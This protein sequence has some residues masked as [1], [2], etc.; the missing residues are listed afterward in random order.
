MDY[1]AREPTGQVS[2]GT[3]ALL[4]DHQVNVTAV[5]DETY[6]RIVQK[7]VNQAGLDE[8]GQVDLYVDPRSQV[9]TI[10]AL[11]VM[12]Q[13]KI[14]D[15]AATA[16]FT[17]LPVE[18]ELE[19]RTYRGFYRINIVLADVRVGDV[20][21]VAYTVRTEEKSFPGRFATRAQ[22]EWGA[23]LHE[24]RV[25]FR[26]PA[27]RPMKVR[28]SKPGFTVSPVT[29][30]DVSEFS[31]VSRDPKPILEEPGRPFWHQPWA[32]M[33]VSDFPDWGEVAGRYV[34]LFKLGKRSRPRLDAL[35][36]E[37]GKGHLD[38]EQRVSQ[39]L[40][41]VQDNIRYTSISIERGAFQPSDPEVVLERRFGDC[42]DK[43]LLLS[44]I[45]RRY[46]IDAT[47]ALVN[48]FRGR[49]LPQGLPSAWVFDHAI[50]RVR[51]AGGEYWVD[52]TLYRQQTPLRELAPPDF[53][54]ALVVAPD[55]TGLAV[56]PRPSPSMSRVDARVEW[57]LRNGQ[58][59]PATMKLE[60]VF[61]GNRAD[62][63]RAT[64]AA[65]SLEAWQASLTPFL[66]RLYPGLRARGLPAVE[67]DPSGNRL[68]VTAHF[69]ID[70][71]F[72]LVGKRWEFVI[73]DE[74]VYSFLEPLRSIA[75]T[76]PLALPYPAQIRQRT[77]VLLPALWRV[78]S[79]D[80]KVENPAFRYTA[81]QRYNDFKVALVR[82]FI[83]LK[84]AVDVAELPRFQQDLKRVDAD[85]PF[86][87]HTT[88]APVDVATLANPKALNK[89]I[90]QL[91]DEARNDS[92][93]NRIVDSLAS[94][95]TAP[96]FG[97]L[98][99]EVRHKAYAADGDLAVG[100][101]NWERGYRSSRAATEFAE[102]TARDWMFLAQGARVAGDLSEAK[103]AIAEIARRW[104]DHLE[105]MPA[106]IVVDIL[107]VLGEEDWFDLANIL[108]KSPLTG[109]NGFAA[110]WRRLA[111]AW[112]EKG[113][114]QRARQVVA[115]I[116][117]PEEMI[118]ARADRRFAAVFAGATTV[119]DIAEVAATGLKR[120]KARTRAHPRSLWVL[121]EWLGELLV[122]K[123]YDEV[124]EQSEEA[125]DALADVKPG[126]PTFH[127]LDAVPWIQDRRARALWALNRRD[128]A[129]GLWTQ[130]GPSVNLGLVYC[131][132]NRAEDALRTIEA[133]DV[134]T[135]LDKI[136][137]SEVRLC[138]TL[139]RKDTGA[140]EAALAAMR[141][142]RAQSPRLY[143]RA[144]IWSSRLD[145]AAAYLRERLADPATRGD[146]LVDVQD[147]APVPVFSR[148][149]DFTAR[150]QQV[151]KREDV[152]KAIKAVGTVES[153]PFGPPLE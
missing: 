63:K 33:E 152:K 53:E 65:Q 122:A 31:Y 10:H 108:S 83:N 123:E 116:D 113:D 114:L 40:Q 92:D 100:L 52:P 24:Q 144:L 49:T 23:P 51:T 13:G 106:N 18:T 36:A 85:S 14:T 124:L 30:R 69:D 146:A 81:S 86:I 97:S 37:L 121:H 77:T 56:I 20:V 19:R 120:L 22:L 6:F 75:R 55:T 79:E 150:W 50:V 73:H 71:V 34:N 141:D 2:N 130:A 78:D 76:T 44:T 67:D 110:T 11:Q 45:L 16:R 26:Y 145:E 58:H 80:F 147:Y 93:F 17:E 29:S 25:R 101:G 91:D 138:A 104:P 28:F 5:G 109:R 9:L 111:L 57:D 59:Q 7:A 148:P 126:T 90:L 48:T 96:A 140:A 98:S 62:L 128:E 84:D 35:A 137:V 94:V 72:H 133:V 1:N 139:A 68:S 12:R 47:P 102:T 39:V 89:L 60:F 70:K 88:I 46:G 143:Q 118:R 103:R 4:T 66:E 135:E 42:K 127:D 87:L 142:G 38:A 134:E 131:H 95:L 112:V 82:E 151:L 54:Q 153:Y 107:A 15:A 64:F 115:L 119:P 8:A 41:H 117:E 43:A 149:P 125:L 21:D 32:I 132:L 74:W 136:E 105:D 129:L 27:S 99:S 3:Y 61:H